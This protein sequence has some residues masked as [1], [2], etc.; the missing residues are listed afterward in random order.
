M[1]WIEGHRYRRNPRYLTRVAAVL[2]SRGVDADA[3]RHLFTDTGEHYPNPAYNPDEV[4]RVLDHVEA[5]GIAEFLDTTLDMMPVGELPLRQA[6]TDK[7][8][9]EGNLREMEVGGY[10]L[11]LYCDADNAA[12]EYKEF[13]HSYTAELGSTCRRRARKDGWRFMKD[14]RVFCPKCKKENL[15][16]TVADTTF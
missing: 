3:P 10:L 8:E 9:R 2:Q 5:C 13:P 1:Q 12:H 6:W 4:L 14:G 7:T 11:E 16:S 15:V